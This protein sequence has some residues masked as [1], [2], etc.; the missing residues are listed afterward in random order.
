MNSNSVIGI[1][2]GNLEDA[3]LACLMLYVYCL[4]DR[5][6][7]NKIYN[8]IEQLLIKGPDKRKSNL[9]LRK[10]S[11][12]RYSILIKN[13]V[14]FQSW[15]ANKV[16]NKKGSFKALFIR[17]LPPRFLSGKR[18]IIKRKVFSPNIA[19]GFYEE[20]LH[21]SALFCLLVKHINV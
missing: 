8:H 13:L 3:R 17:F 15:R 20:N 9:F 2:K 16:V 10:I 19:S 4:S 5:G 14:C 11:S 21:Y 7:L 6:P 18:A 1:S 12:S